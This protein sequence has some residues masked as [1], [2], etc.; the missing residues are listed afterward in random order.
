LE[1]SLQYISTFPQ[2]YRNLIETSIID[3][4]WE[5]RKNARTRNKQAT[6]VVVVVVVVVVTTTTKT[7]MIMMNSGQQYLKDIQQILPLA[8]SNAVT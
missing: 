7:T 4:L 8:L 1:F 3:D 2:S 5:D 6:S